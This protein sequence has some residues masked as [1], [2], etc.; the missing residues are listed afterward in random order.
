MLN[1]VH[2]HIYNLVRTFA[3]VPDK[4]LF[5]TVLLDILK[6]RIVI[7]L[8]VME[9]NN[10]SGSVCG[11]LRVEE[12]QSDGDY[13]IIRTEPVVTEVDE[14]EECDGAPVNCQVAVVGDDQFSGFDL[15]SLPAEQ[16]NALLEIRDLKLEYPDYIPNIN[17]VA[18]ALLSRGFDLVTVAAQAKLTVDKLCN[19]H[20]SRRYKLFQRIFEMVFEYLGTAC[21]FIWG[22]IVSIFRFLTSRFR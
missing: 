5:L 11:M 2:T 13:E 15:R 20:K 17:Y 1:D 6:L 19:L 8:R 7:T 10:C 9:T 21:Y 12:V 16:V 3:E 14:L 18:M 22:I 4:D